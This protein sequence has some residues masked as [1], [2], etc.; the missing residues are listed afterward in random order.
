MKQFPKLTSITFVLERLDNFDSM[1]AM[2]AIV[3]QARKLEVLHLSHCDTFSPNGRRERPEW[4]LTEFR[5]G[6]KALQSVKSDRIQ[7]LSFTTMSFSKQCILDLLHRYRNTLKSLRFAQCVLQDGS[8]IEVISYMKKSMPALGMLNIGR[9]YNAIR[10]DPS[11]P[12]FTYRTVV[13]GCGEKKIRG[14]NEVQA[15]L[16]RILKHPHIDSLALISNSEKEEDGDTRT[17][18]I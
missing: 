6:D 17:S 15:A 18:G 2:S 13:V 9:L 7:S 16:I 4:S 8:W 3:S 1:K 14:E 5:L 10:R 12:H 11:D